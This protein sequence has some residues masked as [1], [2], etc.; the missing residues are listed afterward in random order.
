MAQ[1]GSFALLIALALSVYCFVAGL[2]ALVLTDPATPAKT[3]NRGARANDSF[4]TFLTGMLRQGKE[5]LAETARRAGLMVFIAV[6]MAAV[7]LV[8]AAFQ[9]DF[10]IAYI[11]HHSNR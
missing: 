5:R 6:L 8:I 7:V 11:F 1:L 2:I 9:N 3:K 10:R 4:F